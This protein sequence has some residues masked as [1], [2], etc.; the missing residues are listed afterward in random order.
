MFDIL[1]DDNHIIQS[2]GNVSLMATRMLS[3]RMKAVLQNNRRINIKVS[4][5]TDLQTVDKS[6]TS[7]REVGLFLCI[8]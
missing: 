4:L 5:N 6:P 7:R 1:Y 8:K 2:A 3:K